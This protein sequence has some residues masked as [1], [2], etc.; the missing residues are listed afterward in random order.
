VFYHPARDPKSSIISGGGWDI[1]VSNAPPARPPVDAVLLFTRPIASSVTAPVVRL[2][3][4]STMSTT[5]SSSVATHHPRI[6][7]LLD[8]ST[9]NTFPSIQPSAVRR[10]SATSSANIP[11][12]SRTREYLHPSFRD[13]MMDILSRPRPTER[14]TRGTAPYVRAYARLVTRR[15]SERFFHPS[16][17]GCDARRQPAFLSASRRDAT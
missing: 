4:M 12:T 7:P 17:P 13:E 6:V 16:H 10:P 15:M 3:T 14:S 11:S 9:G 2:P 1:V 5:R 8:P